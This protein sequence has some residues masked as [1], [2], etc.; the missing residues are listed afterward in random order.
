[1]DPKL[2]PSLMAYLISIFLSLE[3]KFIEKFKRA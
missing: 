3:F 2:A 1:M